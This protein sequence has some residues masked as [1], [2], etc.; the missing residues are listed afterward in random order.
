MILRRV[1]MAGALLVGI[2]S[3][4]RAEVTYSY[5]YNNM[6]QTSDSGLNPDS[7]DAEGGAIGA[8]FT[9]DIGATAV[10]AISLAVTDT[11]GSGSFLV[12]LAPNVSGEPDLN[13]ADALW[14]SGPINDTSSFP[15]DA[16]GYWELNFSSIDASV[17]GSTMYWIVTED[18][19]SGTNVSWEYANSSAGNA[20]DNPGDTI[21]SELGYYSG[22]SSANGTNPYVMAVQDIYSVTN[23]GGSA[24]P[25][26]AGLT[27]LAMGFLGLGATRWRRLRFL[28]KPYT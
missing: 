20:S 22:A 2:S 7:V 13:P 1:L 25:E 23:N 19:G 28:Y 8:S 26:P 15:A 14:T 3:V 18:T 5:A 6:A 27:V 11:V 4:A 10:T 9:T 17:S 21:A 24:A 16:N 12:F